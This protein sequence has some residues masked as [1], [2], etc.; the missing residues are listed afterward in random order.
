MNVEP[1]PKVF[2]QNKLGKSQSKLAE[3]EPVV[4]NKR[5]FPLIR[6]MPE[7]TK[8]GTNKSTRAGV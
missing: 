7:E 3:L 8:A 6:L 1:S 2:L 5:E 4:N